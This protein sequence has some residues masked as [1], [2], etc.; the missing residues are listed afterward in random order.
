MNRP[1]CPACG[2][3]LEHAIHVHGETV[4]WKTEAPGA[5]LLTNTSGGDAVLFDM[6]ERET[7]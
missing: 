4:V 7:A 2:G 3:S 1:T 5:V 6:T